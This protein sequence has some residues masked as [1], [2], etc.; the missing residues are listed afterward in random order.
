MSLKY[1]F[2]VNND[3]KTFFMKV[4]FSAGERDDF[5][6]SR[7]KIWSEKIWVKNKNKIFKTFTD[8]KQVLY[9]SNCVTN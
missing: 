6:P 2:I 9:F 1:F 8:Q 4:I 7:K 3:L 5:W